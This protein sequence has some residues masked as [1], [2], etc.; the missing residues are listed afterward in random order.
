MHPFSVF[1]LGNLI[2]NNFYSKHFLIEGMYEKSLPLF[3]FSGNTDNENQTQGSSRGNS[4]FF[5]IVTMNIH[6]Y[7]ITG[8]RRSVPQS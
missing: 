1:F 7:F 3:L 2:L 6:A 5:Y 4:L 8:T